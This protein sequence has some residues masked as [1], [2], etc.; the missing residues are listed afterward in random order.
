MANVIPANRLP[1]DGYWRYAG[2]PGGI[3]DTSAWTIT[4]I[5]G[6]DTTGGASIVSAVN[7]AVTAASARTVLTI[8]TGTF[9]VDG[10]ITLKNDVV[11]RGAKDASYVNLTGAQT[12]DCTVFRISGYQ[13]GIFV[14][15][16]SSWQTP[17]AITGFS[18]YS[19][20][21]GVVVDAGATGVTVASAAGFAA[22]KM[23]RFIQQNN[24]GTPVLSV[25][26]NNNVQGQ[27]VML[28]SVSGTTLYFSPPLGFPLYSGL[29]PTAAMN[30]N[31]RTGIG[32]E[33]IFFD[34]TWQTG[35]SYHV[36][37]NSVHACWVSGVQFF[38]AMQYMDYWNRAVQC[39]FRHSTTWLNRSSNGSYTHGP[40]MA[41]FKLDTSCS[42][43]IIDNIFYRQFPSIQINGSSG[44]DFTDSSSCGNVI[45]YNFST[46]AYNANVDA[47]QDF[48]TSHGPHC[49]LDLYE[50]NIGDK[51]DMDAYYG[52]A[53]NITALRNWIGGANPYAAT[54]NIAFNL[55]RFTRGFN[56]V[57]NLIGKAG[58]DF[59]YS[60]TSGTE[61]INKHYLYRFG[62]PNADNSLFSGS[63][64][65]SS[66]TYWAD[67][68][69]AAG[70]GGFQE[71]DL[72]VQATTLYR[73]NY[74]VPSGYI[75][76]NEALNGDTI[77]QS[78]I[79][80]SI[81][82]WWPRSLTWPPFDPLSPNA[83][84]GAIP[85]GY[86]Y[87]YG[88]NPAEYVYGYRRLGRHLKL[89]GWTIL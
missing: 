81:P 15:V 56:L 10:R 14:G 36:N 20:T 63:V 18:G 68:N 58:Y 62:Y 83:V 67:W 3:P 33:N 28:K 79:Y 17:T 13:A 31:I 42:N 86:R 1:S 29:G 35:Q 40:N 48:E 45:A 70:P 41:G 87:F 34:G 55:G 89:K 50:G 64:Q 74:I 78:Y 88:N 11:L 61:N 43:L 8:G 38:N 44:P 32:I 71:L 60:L 49:Q 80:T 69:T 23:I 6:L 47:A 57:G 73:G 53:A 37:L 75:A 30:L 12:G 19:Q 85:A 82:S 77:P 7:A 72:D 52:S 51:F 59:I 76:T 25:Y 84:T 21:S 24:S 4:S 16:S 65:P 22:D 27:E 2:V 5:T 46:Q 54:H 26:N 9:L 66:G 39:E